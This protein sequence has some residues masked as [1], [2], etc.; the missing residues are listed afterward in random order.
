MTKWQYKLVV[1]R[2]QI[3]E[4]ELNR[5]GAEGWEVVSMTAIFALA[6]WGNCIVILKRALA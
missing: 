4:S 3:V 5:L 1:G 2:P 6:S